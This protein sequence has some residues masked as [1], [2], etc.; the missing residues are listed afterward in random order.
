[1]TFSCEDKSQLEAEDNNMA[2]TVE[3]SQ[4]EGLGQAVGSAKGM[5]GEPPPG[6]RED[7]G[8]SQGMDGR[9]EMGTKTAPAFTKII[10]EGVTKIKCSSCEK[11]CESTKQMKTHITKSH[12][13][14]DKNA[15]KKTIQKVDITEEDISK[16]MYE[17]YGMVQ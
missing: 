11:I 13:K 4:V 16:S 14:K 7:K 15:T 1:M 5:E 17:Q 10:I 9:P 2:S 3:S 12:T 6:M 8:S